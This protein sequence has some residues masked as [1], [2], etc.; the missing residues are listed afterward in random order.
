MAPVERALLSR[1][2]SWL[3][4]IGYAP[5][6]LR[7]RLGRVPARL[8]AVAVTAS[9][10]TAGDDALGL[11]IR[12]WSLGL[13]VPVEHLEQAQGSPTLDDL[14]RAGL[15]QH[16]GGAVTANMAITPDLDAFLL[17]DFDRGRPGRQHV[18]G[19]SPAS[20]T[21]LGLTPRE[22]VERA[23]DLGTGCGVQALALARHTAT[24]VATDI[25][26]RAAWATATGAALGGIEHIDVRVGDGL[27]PVAGEEFDLI[28]SN[29]PFVVSPASELTFRDAGASGDALSR[30]VV[31]DVAGHLRP[32]GLACVLVNWIVREGEPPT[33]AAE[34]WLEDLPVT[35][36]VLHHEVL[37]P[38]RYVQ[39]WS[40]PT[41]TTSAAQ[42]RASTVRWL[43]ALEQL[44]AT[45][46]ASGAIVLRRSDGPSRVRVAAMRQRPQ[47]GGRHVVRMLDAVDRLSGAR[48][49]SLP[50]RRFRLLHDHHIDQRLR[51]GH[52]SY[53]AE[54]ATMRLE[55]T[56]GVVGRIPAELLEVVFALDGR[57]ELAEVTAQVAARSG[58]PASELLEAIRPVVLELYEL[59]LLDAG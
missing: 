20:R 54:A 1:I 25:N 31:R 40:M 15:V 2:G 45:G 46:V 23:L 36:L 18:L 59:G 17:H 22:P 50:S 24:V 19:M 52:G 48:D 29:P 44:A 37:D 57:L 42:Q 21:L 55:H 3:R 4:S 27:A 39:R 26:E 43:T 30:R 7:A 5:A 38:V 34:R 33:L 53:R 51:Y 58:R 47:D 9:E 8:D 56:A 14:E 10:R 41:A 11:A 12:L 6:P 49:A 16:A 13:P 35:A 32:G 28:V